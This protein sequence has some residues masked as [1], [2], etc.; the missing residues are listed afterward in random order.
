M[1]DDR[2]DVSTSTEED[3]QP[4]SELQNDVSLIKTD[5]RQNPAPLPPPLA[6]GY[7]E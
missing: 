3:A 2:I 4:R 1:C 6:V 5:P 7:G